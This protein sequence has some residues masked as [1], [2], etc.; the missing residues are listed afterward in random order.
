MRERREAGKL[1]AK[2]RISRHLETI[3]KETMKE[4]KLGESGMN[5]GSRGL[6]RSK[7]TERGKERESSRVSWLV[8]GFGGP[9]PELLLDN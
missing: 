5:I 3:N 6:S 2:K 8:T 4:G 1:T 9:I 7:G